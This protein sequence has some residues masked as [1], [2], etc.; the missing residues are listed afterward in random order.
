MVKTAIF[1]GGVVSGFALCAAMS[2]EQRRRIV[3]RV[4]GVSASAPAQRLGAA[5]HTAADA[6]VDT[7]VSKAENAAD[8][9][10]SAVG[11]SDSPT[12]GPQT[13]ATR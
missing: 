4:Q 9:V 5:A 8:A 1:V 3:S 12:N 6:I 13:A 7:G 11:P 10:A 2:D